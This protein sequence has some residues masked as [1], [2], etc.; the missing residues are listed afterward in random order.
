MYHFQYF[1]TNP[2]KGEFILEF[3][4]PINI[5]AY[6]ILMKLI[7]VLKDVHIPNDEYIQ[8]FTF[9]EELSKIFNSLYNVL[10]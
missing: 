2:N 1:E 4:F 8:I 5:K 9:I 6:D 10:F 3:E 7:F